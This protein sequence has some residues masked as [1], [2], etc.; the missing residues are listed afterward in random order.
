MAEI[1]GRWRSSS[2]LRVDVV[3]P[4]QRAGPEKRLDRTPV[5]VLLRA[6]D[7]VVG[8]GAPVDGETPGDRLL[9]HRVGITGE[10]VQLAGL[11]LAFGAGHMLD[12][13]EFEKIAGF[14]GVDHEA[15]LHG[16]R[17]AIR[18]GEIDRVNLIAGG[19]CS[20]RRPAGE[21][22]DHAGGKPWQQHLVQHRERDA[23]LVA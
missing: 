3:P 18:K 11:S 9:V 22:P 20:D 6:V 14:G 10:S 15:G 4:D 17:V 19:V 16:D 7:H 5:I 23:W 2:G 21:Q 8:G 13:G 12:A 1:S